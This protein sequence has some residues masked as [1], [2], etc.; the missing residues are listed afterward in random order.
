MNILITSCGRRTQLI[1]YFK[2]SFNDKG[3]IITTDCDKLA[4][5]L[6]FSDKYYITPRIDS[7]NYI[8]EIFEICKKEN[9]KGILSLIDPELSLLSKYK[10]EFNKLGV[11]LI[12]SDYEVNE[13]CFDKYQFYKVLKE[14]GFDCAKT[15]VCIEEFK[16]DL[17]KGKINFPV[18]IK[19]RCGSASL[20]I[21]KI[22]NLEHLE[23]IYKLFPNMIIQEL[24]EGQECGVDCY[25]DLISGEVIS[26]FGK[27][28]IR[29]RAG[30]TDK[31]I[32]FKDDKMFSII[33]ELVK[34]LNLKGVMDIDIFEKDGEYMISE[35]NPRFGGGY[36]IAYECGDNYPENILN[37]LSNKANNKQIG[38][39]EDGKIMV[40]YDSLIMR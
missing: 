36:P 22:D 40:K 35:V 24:I 9:I 17:E 26:I 38:E 34:K 12:G 31:A 23:L 13:M 14:N 21:N 33:D 10:N 11:R 8:S 30:E 25:V 6:Y 7:E 2:E 19:P 16:I 20:G 1:K 15:Y 29:M 18:F 39:Y 4:P 28:K 27:K 37:N 32:S 5:A 3:K